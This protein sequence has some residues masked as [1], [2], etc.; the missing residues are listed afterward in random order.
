MVCWLKV[1]GTEAGVATAG[2][3]GATSTRL[4]PG[5]GEKVASFANGGRKTTAMEAQKAKPHGLE[6]LLSSM[7]SPQ[8]VLAG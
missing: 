6:G 2:G 3:T 7:D 1:G 8:G 4:P 5:R